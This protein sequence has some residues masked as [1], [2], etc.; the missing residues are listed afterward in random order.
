MPSS[1]A[2]V[3]VGLDGA[4]ILGPPG[5]LGIVDMACAYLSP[6]AEYSEKFQDGVWDGYIRASRKQ[7]NFGRTFP[8]GL[9]ERVRQAVGGFSVETD[10]RL[11]A[12]SLQCV[13]LGEWGGFE[14]FDFQELAVEAAL[15]RGGGILKMPI[16]SGKTLTAA[17]LLWRLGLRAV[18]F[19]PS[20][21]LVRQTY[22]AFKAALPDAHI[23]VVGGGIDDD[24]SGDIVVTTVQTVEARKNRGGSPKWWRSF[25]GAF[26]V[27]VFDEVHHATGQGQKWRET[28]LGMRCAYRFGLTGTLDVEDEGQALWSEAV[29]GP[30]IFERTMDD[31]VER[32]RLTKADVHFLLYDTPQQ[33]AVSG[34]HWASTYKRGIVEAAGRNEAICWAAKK[35]AE[36]GR[37]VM[38]D[39]YRV[40]HARTLA[41]MLRAQHVRVG[42]LVG[43]KSGAKALKWEEVDKLVDGRSQVL[44]TNLLGEGVDIP[45]LE[46]VINAEGGSDSHAATQRWRNLTAAEGKS[47]ATIY[48]LADL[49]H[50]RLAQHTE[51]RRRLYTKYPKC[52]ER[53]DLLQVPR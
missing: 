15:A 32:G 6:G 53:V 49:H 17:R 45:G 47:R 13:D 2:R 28:M 11:T 29:A 52:F 20:E 18:F 39:C 7:G 36:A 42:L 26:D 40:G 24:A 25:R 1:P 48:E 3:T 37:A 27:T 10:N 43:K 46:V 41:T 4:H 51:A 38:V 44:V 35:E 30:I 5:L 16:R 9:L 22:L 14:P 34:E 12:R 50:P 31:M 21:I 33:S 23:T 19:A 8:F